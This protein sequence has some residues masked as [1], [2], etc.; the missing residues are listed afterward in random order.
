MFAVSKSCFGHEE[1][2]HS[3]KMRCRH[4]HGECNSSVTSV[5]SV[6]SVAPQAISQDA[7]EPSVADTI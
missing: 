3:Q 4:L 2:D 7:P 1:H 6:A 5:P